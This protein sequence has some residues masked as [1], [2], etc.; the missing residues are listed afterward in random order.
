LLRSEKF[1][2]EFLSLVREKIVLWDEMRDEVGI[3]G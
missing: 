2:K 3:F 1:D